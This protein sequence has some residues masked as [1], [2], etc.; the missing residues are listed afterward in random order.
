[1]LRPP[2]VEA[3]VAWHSPAPTTSTTPAAAA[4]L[5]EGVA[6]GVMSCHR[7]AASSGSLWNHL[8]LERGGG[9]GRGGRR[10]GGGG[11]G[12]VG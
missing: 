8:L 12:V 3:V 5:D 2:L 9:G 4:H 11:G 7:D 1:M 6:L 10:D